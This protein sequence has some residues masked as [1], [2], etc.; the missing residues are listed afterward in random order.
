MAPSLF[1]VRGLHPQLLQRKTCCVFL[2]LHARRGTHCRRSTGKNQNSVP[3]C[4]FLLSH[5]TLHICAQ[6]DPAKH[7]V[8][9]PLSIDSS[10][11]APSCPFCPR[12]GAPQRYKRYASVLQ[13]LQRCGETS[14]PGMRTLTHTD[15]AYVSL[16]CVKTNQE[17]PPE[18][19]SRP[20]PTRRP[21]L[22]ALTLCLSPLSHIKRP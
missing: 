9:T 4:F 16:S 2:G 11:T 17:S 5:H 1:K 8:L 15:H 7:T 18:A 13:D 3:D 14:P 6:G 19:V 10:N 21:R 12:V 22:T 20:S